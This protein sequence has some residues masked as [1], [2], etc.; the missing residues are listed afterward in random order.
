MWSKQ[1]RG[2]D[3]LSVTVRIALLA[4]AFAA[5][6]FTPL[7][8]RFLGQVMLFTQ[9]SP[10]T[11]AGAISSSQAGALYALQLAVF[12]AVALPRSRPALTVADTLVFGTAPGLLLAWVGNVAADSVCFALSR[13]FAGRAVAGHIP[14]PAKAAFIRCGSAGCCAALLILPWAGG[15]AG[16]VS[17][18]SPMPWRRWLI[19]AACGEIFGTLAYGLFGSRYAAAIPYRLLVGMRALAALLLLC[20]LAHELYCR[21]HHS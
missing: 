9:R 19:G 17:G 11:L 20:T 18:L 10:Q 14:E 7:Y 16:Y 4:A 12:R 15:F 6:R 2:R 13:L 1:R 3:I 8:E 5:V 21:K